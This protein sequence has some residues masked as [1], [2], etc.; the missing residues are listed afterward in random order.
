MIINR[1]KKKEE[2]ES[3]NIGESLNDIC[4]NM[5]IARKKRNF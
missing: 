5:I 3:K 2:K 4:T 1:W